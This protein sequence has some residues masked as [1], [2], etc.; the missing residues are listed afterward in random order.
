M[1]PL[2]DLTLAGRNELRPY[3]NS[4]SSYD[5]PMRAKSF[6]LLFG[7]IHFSVVAPAG[8]AAP[9]DTSGHASAQTAGEGPTSKF[10]QKA[11]LAVSQGVI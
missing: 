1:A 3:T 4:E 7:L 10:D 9:H 11:A 2:P 5:S 8:V 6:V